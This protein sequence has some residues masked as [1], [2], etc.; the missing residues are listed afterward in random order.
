MLELVFVLDKSANTRPALRVTEV[1]GFLGEAAFSV[2]VAFLFFSGVSVGGGFR[3]PIGFFILLSEGVRT[4]EFSS[5]TLGLG[6]RDSFKP[7]FSLREVERALVFG[8]VTGDRAVREGMVALL[9]ATCAGVVDPLIGSS[10]TNTG[11]FV[12]DLF[13][14]ETAE[15]SGVL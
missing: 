6:T 3:G 13:A 4:M 12:I 2:P 7:I 11:V 14:L 15:D 9:L 8:V 1:V 5:R 10:G